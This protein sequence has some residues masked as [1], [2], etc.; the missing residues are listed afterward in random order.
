MPETSGSRIAVRLNAIEYGARDINLYRFGS[1][2]GSPLPAIAPGAHI[3]LEIDDDFRRSY[4]L[5]NSGEA[6]SE[7]IIGVLSQEA[8]RGGSKNWHASSI[9]GQRYWISKPRNNFALSGL[10]RPSYLFAGGIG[11]TPIINM[12]RHLQS[13][14][15]QVKLFYWVRSL[16]HAVFAAELLQDPNVKIFEAGEVVSKEMSISELLKQIPEQAEL[17]CCGP[18]AMLLDFEQGTKGRPS[19]FVHIER[20][21]GAAPQ[22]GSEGFSVKLARRGIA[23]DV[24][25]GQTI[26]QVC[27][28]RGIDVSYSCE[29][30][31]CG[32]C[33]VRVLEGIVSHRDSFKSPE[34]HAAM[35]TMMICSSV[36]TSGTLVIDI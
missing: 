17:Y 30:G 15:G 32:A 1:V 20:F 35:G 33:E 11:I 21:T 31:I 29:E 18:Q 27:L 28:E 12:Y 36:A 8:G 3:D 7:Y 34:E 9:V 22:G 4:S 13:K 16:E 25:P 23:F 5:V 19:H 10:D 6:P 26:L 24:Q 2:D 14:A